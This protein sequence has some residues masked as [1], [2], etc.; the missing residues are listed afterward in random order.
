MKKLLI[1]LLSAFAGTLLHAQD[2][3]Q[4]D[5]VVYRQAAVMDSTL[6]G[7]SIFSLLPSKDKG[8]KAT[9][10]VSQSPAIASALQR[11][12]NNG[13]NRT[14]N[15]YRVR[16]YFDNTQNA[17]G[18]SE[19]ALGRFLA[20]TRGVAAY[21]SYQNPFFKVTVGDFRTRSEAVEL[22]EKIKGDFPSAFVV[23]EKINYPV[24][25][26]SKSFVADTVKVYRQVQ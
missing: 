20:I 13:S 17:R 5:S 1:I 16:I 24:A 4:V 8:G 19:Q 22:L 6:R 18:A 21:R 12:I 14:M 11:H 2:I 25:D 15:G 3:V 10:N 7:K 9:V 26:R 23:K